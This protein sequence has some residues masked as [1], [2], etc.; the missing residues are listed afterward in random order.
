MG[1]EPEGRVK[2]LDSM[3]SSVRVSFFELSV[4]TLKGCMICLIFRSVGWAMGPILPQGW[5]IR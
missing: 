1:F 2:G 5:L 3:L 4:V